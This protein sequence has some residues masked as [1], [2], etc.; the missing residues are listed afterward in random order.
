MASSCLI[1]PEGRAHHHAV[2]LLHVQPG[3]EGR[4]DV[5]RVQTLHDDG[6]SERLP[7]GHQADQCGRSRGEQ[8]GG[9]VP[10]GELGSE[11]RPARVS[12]PTYPT[13]AQFSE[14][15]GAINTHMTDLLGQGA[16][17]PAQLP[18]R[19][20][21]A[22]FHPLPSVLRDSGRVGAAS[23]GCLSAPINMVESVPL[24]SRGAGRR[25]HPRPRRLP[26]VSAGSKGRPDDLCISRD[27]DD[28][29][30][31][32]DSGLLRDDGRRTR[33]HPTRVGSRPRAGRP[34]HDADSDDVSGRLHT[35]RSGGCTFSTT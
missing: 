14:Q 27:R 9:P 8:R 5:E 7:G 15:W 21:A 31:R 3:A 18:G 24:D 33:R 25:S 26:D 11:E 1:A 16:G 28:P 23:R 12:T 22:Q 17:K 10:D 4:C 6:A 2:R 35:R 19:C 32:A 20:R 13:F 34:Q 30:R 29:Q